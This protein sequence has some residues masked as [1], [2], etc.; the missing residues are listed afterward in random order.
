MRHIVSLAVVVVLS[1][2]PGFAQLKPDSLMARTEAVAAFAKVNQRLKE[3]RTRIEA[4][5][6]T[7]SQASTLVHA[8]M[9]RTEEVADTARAALHRTPGF[10]GKI[11]AGE[12]RQAALA[13]AV[14]VVRA[15]STDTLRTVVTKMARGRRLSSGDD[16][17]VATRW[18]AHIQDG[19]SAGVEARERT[20]DLYDLFS[21]QDEQIQ[22]LRQQILALAAADSSQAVRVDSVGLEL[23]VVAHCTATALGAPDSTGRRPNKA[24]KRAALDWLATHF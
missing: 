21:A 9:E 14:E 5:A 20:A 15:D 19:V 1:A 18:L 8:V 7:A 10:H 11:L 24:D 6:D 22:S 3:N 17:L 16:R 23:R 12:Q 13:W 4:V 2:A